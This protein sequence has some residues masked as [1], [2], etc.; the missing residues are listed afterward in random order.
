MIS[1]IVLKSAN[2][3]ALNFLCGELA[4]SIA[5]LFVRLSLEE[6]FNRIPNRNANRKKVVCT[7]KTIRTSIRSDNLT[8][9]LE[10]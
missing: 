3:L 1:R 5:R 6:V 8:N 4:I 9:S 7:R 10:K 2:I